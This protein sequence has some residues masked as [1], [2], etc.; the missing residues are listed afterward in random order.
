[1]KKSNDIIIYNDVFTYEQN[2]FYYENILRRDF[3][4]GE[5]DSEKFPPTGLVSNIS[6][7]DPL[8]VQLDLKVQQLNKTKKKIRRAYVNLFLPNERPFFHT[9]GNI[10]TFLFYFN[11]KVDLNENGETQFF[12]DNEI[13]GILPVPGSAVSFDGNILHRATSFRS[14]PRITVA[15]KYEIQTK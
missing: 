10:R 9:D 1:M 2:M 4:Y 12:F 8:F 6:F 13:R 11:P 5:R 14:Y 7:H 3:Y 15:L